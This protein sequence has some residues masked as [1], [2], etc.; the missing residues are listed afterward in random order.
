LASLF[1][2]LAL[3]QTVHV[4]DADSGPGADFA[5]IHAAV[6]A[7]ADGDVLLVR[8]GEYSAFQLDGKGLT[9][10]AEPGAAV[11]ASQYVV[12]NLGP[13]QRVRIRGIDTN[14]GGVQPP[15]IALLDNL[16]PVWIEDVET[17]VFPQAFFSGGLLVSDCTSVVV[18]RSVFTPPFL[19]TGGAVQIASSNVLMFDCAI[20]GGLDGNT[21]DGHP[22]VLLVDGFLGLFGSSVQGGAG[23]GGPFFCGNGGDGIH[24]TGTAPALRLVDSTVAGGPSEDGCSGGVDGLDLRVDAGTVVNASGLARSVEI[25]SPHRDDEAATATYSGVPGDLVFALFSGRPLPQLS[26][27]VLDGFLLVRPPLYVDFVGVVP[28]SGTLVQSLPLGDLG[29]GIQATAFHVQGLFREAGTAK[30]VLGSVSLLA[31]VDEAF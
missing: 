9:I 8:A 19:I 17:V 28:A 14:G 24:L 1:A 31:I 18:V 12:K 29:P 11:L 20:E 30:L 16:G 3:A 5:D 10:Q 25:T 13:A 23:G 6:A 26:L 22:G 27:G 21:V 7:A 4:V 2:P 15:S